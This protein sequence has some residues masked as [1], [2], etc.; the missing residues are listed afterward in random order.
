M[1]DLRAGQGGVICSFRVG[2]EIWRGKGKIVGG[3][4]GRRGTRA[5]EGSHG[6]LRCALPSRAKCIARPLAARFCS[7]TGATGTGGKE[8][9]GGKEEATFGPRKSSAVGGIRRGSARRKLQGKRNA[10][11]Q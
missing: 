4:E 6:C 1:E 2:D 3:R 10:Q 5:G 7:I 11:L 9:W 8:D